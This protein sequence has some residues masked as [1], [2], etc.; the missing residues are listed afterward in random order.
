MIHD[1]VRSKSFQLF[2]DD[3]QMIGLMTNI[4]GNPLFQLHN[5]QGIPRL[6]CMIKQDG[7]LQINLLT[8]G[9]MTLAA[10]HTTSDTSSRFVLCNQYGVGLLEIETEND[11]TTIKIRNAEGEIVR[12]L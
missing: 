10:L 1:V 2:N 7:N 3:E 5:Q 9:G 12:Q 6:I 11:T 4:D 8:P